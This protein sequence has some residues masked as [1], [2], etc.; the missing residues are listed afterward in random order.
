MWLE[1]ITNGRDR[2]VLDDIIDHLVH[3]DVLRHAIGQ[4]LP[5]G[6]VARVLGTTAESA[7]D[8]DIVTCK[9]DL[10]QTFA[11][12]IEAAAAKIAKGLKDPLASNRV[13]LT[14]LPT[15][16]VSEQSRADR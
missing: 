13:N 9:H 7:A 5:I 3:V 10:H 14:H 6:E 12:A 4:D 11:P 16:A 8:L 15:I 2:I 1:S